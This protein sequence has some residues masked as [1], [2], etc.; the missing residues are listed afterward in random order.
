MSAAPIGVF[1]SGVGG[2]SVLREIRGALPYEE[3]RCVADSGAAPY[4]ER[5]A[6]LTVARARCGDCFAAVSGICGAGGKR[7]MEGRKVDAL[8]DKTNTVRELFWTIGQPAWVMPVIA[9]LWS[10][11]ADAHALPAL[12]L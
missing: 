6:E 11:A 10:R 7:R 8:M 1:D 3:L 12:T 9:K 5:P 2:L 4:G